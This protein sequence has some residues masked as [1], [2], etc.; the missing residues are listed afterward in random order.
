MLFNTLFMHIIAEKNI[1]LTLNKLFVYLKEAG[2]FQG[3][4]SL[5]LILTKPLLRYK[6]INKWKILLERNN[7][8]DNC[9]KFWEEI[10]KEHFENIVSIVRNL[11]PYRPL[12]KKGL[13]V[14]S[15]MGTMASPIGKG[16][17]LI[18]FHARNSSGFVTECWLLFKSKA[19]GH[20]HKEMNSDTFQF[21]LRIYCFHSS[22]ILLLHYPSHCNGQ[23]ILSF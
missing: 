20:Y 17:M 22:R 4:R 19:T 10:R 15:T 21:G 1:P 12:P 3:S 7:I 16:E 6:P 13:S 8:V 9:C 11:G 23:C 2:L 5:L 14:V 18:L